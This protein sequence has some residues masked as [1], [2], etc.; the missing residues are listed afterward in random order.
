[1]IDDPHVCVGR[2]IWLRR[3]LIEPVFKAVIG[4]FGGLS[5]RE[6]GRG[7]ASLL[8][9][10]ARTVQSGG[11]ALTGLERGLGG[12]EKTVSPAIR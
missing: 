5:G 7:G 4:W 11:E 3:A 9:A 6:G 10:D 2:R 8:Q 1:M 12:L